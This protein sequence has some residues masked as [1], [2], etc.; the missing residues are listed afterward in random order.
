MTNAEQAAAVRPLRAGVIGLGLIGSRYAQQFARDP[1]TDLVALVDVSPE[2]AERVTRDLAAA[3]TIRTYADY[4]DMFRQEQL[5]LV[6]VVTPDSLHRD[7]LVSAAQAGVRYIVSEKPLATT[8]ADAH[9]IAAAVAAA[10]STLMVNFDNRSAPLDLAVHH[11]VQSGLM[12]AVVYGDSHLDDNISVPTQMWGMASH[13]WRAQSSSAH[14]LLSHV[15]DLMHWYLEPDE[16]VG[17]RAIAQRQVLDATMDVYDAWLQ[18]RSGAV[19]RV[20]SEWNRHMEE[21]VEFSTSLTGAKGGIVYHKLPGFGARAGLRACFADAEIAD[22]LSLQDRLAARDI[23][24]RLVRRYPRPSV[25]TAASSTIN[26]ELE[27]LDQL[28]APRNVVAYFLDAI[29]EQQAIPSS[30]QGNG[31][32]PYLESGLKQVRVIQAITDSAATGDP[33]TLD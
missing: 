6:A 32:F 3:Q 8:L 21:L 16:V 14:F 10:G 19:V 33:V 25:S 23:R 7:P 20:K 29:Q 18:F 5:D 17:V 27:P 24:S 9:A 13:E 12:G 2:R 26:L 11:I 22:V 4:A 1:R 28:P 31:S 30:W 15:V